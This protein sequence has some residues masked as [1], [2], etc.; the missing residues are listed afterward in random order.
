MMKKDHFMI[1]LKASLCLRVE[2]KKPRSYED[3]IEIAKRKEWKLFRMSQLGMVDSL[4]IVVEMKRPDS[5]I[6][7]ASIEVLRLV[8]PPVVPAMA[9]MVAVDDGL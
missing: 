9:A 7:R 2:L 3:A 4:P 8:V 6:Q 1:G 5:I